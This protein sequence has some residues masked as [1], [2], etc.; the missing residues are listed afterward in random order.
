MLLYAI[1]S[2]TL[3]FGSEPERHQRLLAQA[4]QLAQRGVDYFQIREK[5]LA[6][7]ELSR[8]AQKIVET[9][10]LT[11]S[12]MQV[13]LNGSAEIALAS[14]C[15]GIHLP[16]GSSLETAAEARRLFGNANRGIMVSAACASPEQAS[17]WSQ[18]ADLLLFA[19]VFEKKLA[20]GSLAGQGLGRLN[21]AVA[22][23]QS[24]PVLALGGITAENAP[25]ALA[26]GASGVAAIRLFQGQDWQ[27]LRDY[28]R[29][30]DPP[31]D[32]SPVSRR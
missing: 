20:T 31:S 14:G 12:P 17:F 23:A 19:P 26:A 10:R 4:A 2:R 24:R 3:F 21:E 32:A 25:A 18:Q 11:R 1:S 7:D 15:D 27:R 9:V 30:G 16:G 22:A 13:L 8:L 29:E 5:D 28:S 6:L